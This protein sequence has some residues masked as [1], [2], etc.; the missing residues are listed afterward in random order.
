M[1][2][3]WLYHRSMVQLLTEKDPKTTMVRR[4]DF[5]R[6]ISNEKEHSYWSMY[7]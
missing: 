4:V 1:I 7:E 5:G 3:A 6:E 2:T